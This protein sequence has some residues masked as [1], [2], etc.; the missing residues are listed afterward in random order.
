MD[1]DLFTTGHFRLRKDVFKTTE[2]CDKIY[3][4]D[5]SITKKERGITNPKYDFDTLYFTAGDI[6]DFRKYALLPLYYYDKLHPVEKAS[7][8]VPALQTS[9]VKSIKSKLKSSLYS[10]IDFDSII[11]TFNYM[12]YKFS[13]GIFIA[14]RDNKLLVFLPFQNMHFRNDWGFRLV[15]DDKVDLHRAEV[16]QSKWRANGHIVRTEKNA[17]GE[18][19][20]PIIKNMFQT[21]C[22]EKTVPDCEFFINRRDWLILTADQTEAYDPLFGKGEP[23]HSHKYNKYCPILSFAKREGYLDIPC[24]TPDDWQCASGLIFPEKCST[25]YSPKSIS[26]YNI[27][28]ETKKATAVFRGKSTGLGVTPLTNQR[29]LVHKMTDDEQK[30][31]KPSKKT[32][33]DI[34]T[35]DEDIPDKDISDT[36]ADV[37]FLD[38]GVVDDKP[39]RPRLTRGSRILTSSKLSD[40]GLTAMSFM[41]KTLQSNHKYMLY[42][43]GHSYAYRLGPDLLMNS[44]VLFMEDHSYPWF[45]DKFIKGEHY[46]SVKSDGSN[47]IDK[48]KWCREHDTEAEAIAKKSYDFG[49]KYITKKETLTYLQTVMY[50]IAQNRSKKFLTVK[51]KDI[52]EKILF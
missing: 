38:A 29:L 34:I 31:L 11:N 19:Y 40:F 48:I 24:V 10:D 12:Y 15:V 14:I 39:L 1:K 27:R 18:T 6:F 23:L 50:C 13:R 51:P 7:F 8:D 32:I 37:P 49:K 52:L 3:K 41:S 33:I 26:E 21:L 42:I 28:W 25:A 5:K 44:V 9:Y 17:V 4:K 46:I 2:E 22:A 16:D 43:R 45:W 36:F 35:P 20:E 30:R 47:L